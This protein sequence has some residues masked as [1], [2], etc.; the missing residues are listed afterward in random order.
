V[1]AGGRLAASGRL[2]DILAFEVRGWELVVSDLK[3]DAL[4]R[5]ASNATRTTE[6]SPGRYSIELPKD[7]APDRV[8]A[9]LTAA[10]AKLV[11]LNPVR[12]TLEDFFIKRIAEAGSARTE[13]AEAAR[14]N[15]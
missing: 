8:L 13:F 4:A 10:G 9:D 14:A 7:R 11:S 3:P 6:I 1:V 5:L 12:D 2:S 15:D